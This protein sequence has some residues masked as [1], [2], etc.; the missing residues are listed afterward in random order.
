MRMLFAV[1]FSDG[2]VFHTLC[3]VGLSSYVPET[4]PDITPSIGPDVWWVPWLIIRTFAC[5]ARSR[6]NLLYLV[7]IPSSIKSRHFTICTLMS[8]VPFLWLEPS[9][10]SNKALNGSGLRDGLTFKGWIMTLRRFLV[11]PISHL[12][13]EVC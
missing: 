9:R 7:I 10:L 1:K 2:R 4:Y 3:R 11:N 12:G 8:L 5:V 6:H 13:V